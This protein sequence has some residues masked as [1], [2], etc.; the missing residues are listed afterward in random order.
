MEGINQQSN[1]ASGAEHLDALRKLTSKQLQ[2][3]RVA[4]IF[5]RDRIDRGPTDSVVFMYEVPGEGSEQH[6]VL[7]ENIQEAGLSERMKF[8]EDSVKDLKAS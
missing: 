4:S 3:G 7:E 8:W 5:E 2:N 1:E 6:I